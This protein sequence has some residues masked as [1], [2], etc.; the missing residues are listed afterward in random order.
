[1]KDVTFKY[2]NSEEYIFENLNVEFQN[3][4]NIIIGANGTGK[5]TLLGLIG[6][7][8][9]PEKGTL[10]SFSENFSYIGATPFIFQKKFK[11]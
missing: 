5:S 2:S 7:V 11:G 4:H 10:T 1:M 3:T 9:I 8:L 6:N